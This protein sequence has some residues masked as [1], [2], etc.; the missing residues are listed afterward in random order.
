VIKARI[1]VER[2]EC[3]MEFMDKRNRSI[4]GSWDVRKTKVHRKLEI[5]ADHSSTEDDIRAIDCAAVPSIN[6]TVGCG[7]ENLIGVL[8]MF[9]YI[10]GCDLVDE[11]EETF[12]NN[13]LG[14]PRAAA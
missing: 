10:N 13:C 12:E 9:I 3:A 7:N 11:A 5:A 6:S 14:L 4:N 2:V 8:V 1:A